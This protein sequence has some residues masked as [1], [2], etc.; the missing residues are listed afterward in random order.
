MKTERFDFYWVLVFARERS[1]Q[2]KP[3]L[4]VKFS[5]LSADQRRKR[6][7]FG[8]YLQPFSSVTAFDALI[9]KMI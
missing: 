7:G 5:P 2:P 9:G 1:V 4:E 6:R 3:F 8:N